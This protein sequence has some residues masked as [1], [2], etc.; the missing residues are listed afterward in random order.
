MTK[1]VCERIA[2]VEAARDGRL[3]GAERSSFEAHF[4]GCLV[5]RREHERLE[6]LGATLREATV[7]IDEL[8]SARLR[9]RI[10]EASSD[11][12]AVAVRPT[13]RRRVAFA[14]AGAIACVVLAGTGAIGVSGRGA[15][16]LVEARAFGDAHFSREERSHREVV[17]LDDGT[18]EFTV[19]RGAPPRRLLVRVPDGTIE[20]RGTR[21]RV[22]VHDRHTESIEVL[23]GIVAFARDGSPTIVL[24]AGESYRRV[25][26][27]GAGSA[28]DDAARDDAEPVA[29]DTPAPVPSRSARPLAEVDR[30]RVRAGSTSRVLDRLSEHDESARRSSPTPG[31]TVEAEEDAAYLHVL[32]AHAR[33]DR[34]AAIRAADEYLRRHPDGFRRVEV[35]RIRAE[36]ATDPVHTTP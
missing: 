29:I 7:A 35:I 32:A 3:S 34:A 17:D 16:P 20:D 1:L 13:S 12:P 5:C 31:A 19:H 30:A 2:E 18:V 22:R 10:V 25:A 21:F 36:A 15:R 11:P 23:E 24:H 8:R 26:T 27:S 4:A 33:D 6:A 28:S 14:V 9:R